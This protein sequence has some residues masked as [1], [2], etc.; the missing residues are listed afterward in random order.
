MRREHKNIS[1]FWVTVAVVVVVVP[2]RQRTD[3]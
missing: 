3:M 2:A 1:V